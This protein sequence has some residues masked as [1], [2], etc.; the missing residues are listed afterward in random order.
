MAAHTLYYVQSVVLVVAVSSVVISNAVGVYDEPKD[1]VGPG[2][3][4]KKIYVDVPAGHPNIDF[5][6][7]AI[8][9]FINHPSL[10][11]FCTQ[12]KF[13]NFAKILCF[14]HHLLN[15][16]H[17]VHVNW[18]ALSVMNPLPLHCYTK[19]CEKVPGKAGI[20]MY[21]LSI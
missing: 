9:S 10:C 8:F 2:G 14:Y 7:I 11:Q 20:Y 12:N 4:K 15:M 3:L 16:I 19:M 6:Y 17:T 1:K 5:R 21:T 13:L 18:V